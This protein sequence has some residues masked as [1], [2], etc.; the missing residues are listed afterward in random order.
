[1]SRQPDVIRIADL[2]EPR[3]TDGQAAA[4]AYAQTVPVELSEQVVLEAA[5][6]QTGLSDFGA[7]DFRARLRVWLQAAEEDTDL[8]A[9]GRLGVFSNCVRYLANRLRVEA[10]VARH[11]EILQVAVEQPIIVAGL[12]RSGTTHLVNLIAAD[13]RLRSLPYWESME[14]VPVRGDGPGRDGRDPRW[15]RCRQSYEQMIAQMP[16]L[17][18]M[19]DMP[20]EHIHEE[21]E[22]QELDFGTYLLEW[23]ARVPRWRDYYRE[24]DLRSSY[25]YLRK[26]LQVLTWFR[27]PRRWVLKSPQHLEQLV[28]LLATFPDATIAITH[29]DPVAVIQS[30]ITMLAYGDR[31]R[32]TRVDP[33][34]LAA[35]WIDRVERLLRACVRDRDRLPATQA[36]DVPFHALMADDLG[37]VTRIYERAG[38]PMTAAARAELARYGTENPRGKHGQVVYD[39]RG[40]FG[41]EPA[42]VRER[43]GFYFERFAVRAENQEEQA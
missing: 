17:P 30:A 4:L 29:R 27:G 20:P 18:A 3:L 31:M 8:N 6:R 14:P 42:A 35:Y 1:M 25:A 39:L 26:V 40:D 24:L 37:M 5:R 41:I 21:I 7:D 23:L 15:T 38:L 36:I 33:A 12:P 43:L 9:L 19:H 13:S 32:R 34:G 2:A 16:L 28:P 10:V 22:L 11:P